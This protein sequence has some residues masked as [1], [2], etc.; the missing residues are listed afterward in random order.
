MA[1]ILIIEDD[2]YVRR[3]YGRLFSFSSNQVEMMAG[4]ENILDKIKAY[5]P[6]LILLDI[7]MPKRNGLEIL[8]MIKKDS[9]TRDIQIVMLSNLGDDQ[10]V[11]K[12][13]QLGATGFIIKSNVPSDLLLNEV[14]KYINQTNSALNKP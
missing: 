14:E 9:Q 6:T 4:E 11:K 10:T 12:A 3:F 1:K 5:Q 13:Y 7:M 8:E 2:P